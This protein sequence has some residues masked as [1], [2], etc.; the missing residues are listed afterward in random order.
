MKASRLQVSGLKKL[1]EVN[2]IRCWIPDDTNTKLQNSRG[3]PY[4]QLSRVEEMKAQCLPGFFNHHN[5][6]NQWIVLT[7]RFR[8]DNALNSSPNHNSF[9]F[10]LIIPTPN[11]CVQCCLSTNVYIDLVVW[12]NLL[13]A[14]TGSI[15][16]SQQTNTVVTCQLFSAWCILSFLE[17]GDMKSF[18]TDVT[19]SSSWNYTNQLWGNDS[20]ETRH[21]ST[22]EHYLVEEAE[23]SLHLWIS[24]SPFILSK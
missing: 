7:G 12:L 8:C 22:K 5:R 17:G 13:H 3:I 19:G 1:S 6:S 18:L 14:Y 21:Y 10:P 24:I 15:W 4:V 16:I 23:L 11:M 9:C 2:S 20:K